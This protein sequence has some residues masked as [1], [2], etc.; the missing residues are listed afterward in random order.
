[1]PKKI[2]AGVIAAIVVVAIALYAFPV[3]KVS[4]IEVEGVQNADA[5][6]VKE[7]A[8]VGSSA[9]MLRVD[10]DAVA[11]K[12]AQVPWVEQ[13]TVSRAWPSTLKVQVTEHTPVAYF[14]NGNEVSAVNEAGK[15]FLKGVAPEGAKEIAGVKPEDSKAITAATTA[16]TALHPKVREKLERVEAKTAESLVLQFAE[17]KT[18]VWGSAE[19]ASEKAEATRVVLTQEGK[20][21]NVS[22]PA[23]PSGRP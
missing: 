3:L 15:V 14:R 11:E 13:V 23:M 17:G 2:I 21:W 16:I 1:M 12:V 9:N 20:K 19:R 10:T 6:V 4:S 18:V 8:S 7:A 5:G 22:N